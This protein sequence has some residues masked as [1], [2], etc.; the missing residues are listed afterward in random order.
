MHKLEEGWV[1]GT[2]GWGWNEA[3]TRGGGCFPVPRNMM[4]SSC[5]GDMGDDD[6]ITLCPN[7]KIGGGSLTCRSQEH[8]VVVVPKPE[9]GC[10]CFLVPWN[11]L[12]AILS[13]LM[14]GG[15]FSSSQEY[16]AGSPERRVVRPSLKRARAVFPVQFSSTRYQL[17]LYAQKPNLQFI[18]QLCGQIRIND[19]NSKCTELLIEWQ[20]Y[21]KE[22]C[23]VN[24]MALEILGLHG[25]I[26]SV[27]IFRR[28]T[29][30]WMSFMVCCWNGLLSSA[31]T[32]RHTWI[33]L[34]VS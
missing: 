25:Q 34:M 24:C 12:R 13:M 31:M 23:S 18:V 27:T 1:P 3:L 11:M 33:R 6:W 28:Q 21:N 2:W 32:S 15:V 22:Q 14:I 17:R 8:G 10:G 20:S 30:E 4:I 19:Y 9:E 29:I 16:W 7:L 26:D 5:Q